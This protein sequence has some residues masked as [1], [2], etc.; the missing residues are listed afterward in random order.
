MEIF[1]Q[2]LP[3]L[4]WDWIH[5][6]PLRRYGWFGDFKSWE[7]AEKASAGY[8]NDHILQKVKNALMKVKNNEAAFERDS[9]LF[10]T[11]QHDWPIIGSLTWVAAQHDGILNV[12][13]FGGSLGSTYYQ[14]RHILKA[15]KHVQWNVIEQSHFVKTGKEFF[16][17]ERLRFYNSIEECLMENQVNLILLSSV[18]SYIRE[19]YELLQKLSGFKF[20]V[21]DKMPLINSENDRIT[22]QKVPP[23]IY[24]ASYPAWF[25]SERKFMNY[26]LQHFEIIGDFDRDIVAN[27]PADFKGF[28]FAKN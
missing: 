10:D 13:D 19:P 21:I 12:L 23:S 8:D 1:K 24:Q 22:I 14:N 6:S 28:L 25:F 11:V 27:F 20:M 5:Q 3:P 2:L 4:V 15:L 9:V 16:E 18:L 17:D 26:I 7:E